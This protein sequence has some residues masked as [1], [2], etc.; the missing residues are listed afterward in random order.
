MIS[1]DCKYRQIYNFSKLFKNYIYVKKKKKF[2]QMRWRNYRNIFIYFGN[3][4][5]F[6]GGLCVD[7]VV[8]DW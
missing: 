3:F 7:E 4:F 6:C 2:V 5:F 8:S 1:R